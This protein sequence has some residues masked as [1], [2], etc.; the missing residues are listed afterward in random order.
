MYKMIRRTKRKGRD[1]GEV[2]LRRGKVDRYRL[3]SVNVRASR[4][5]A[6]F[7]PEAA[8]G[9]HRMTIHILPYSHSTM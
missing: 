5:E 2:V 8:L 1:V 6:G 9:Y 7:G 4:K 3:G